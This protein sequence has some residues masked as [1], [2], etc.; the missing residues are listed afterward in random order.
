MKN[1]TIGKRII[2]GFAAILVLSTILAITSFCL[3]KHSSDIAYALATDPLP[4]AVAMDDL[5]GTVADAHI[6]FLRGLIAKTPEDLKALTDGLA[7]NKEH[8]AKAMKDY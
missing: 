8:N 2:A 1:W 5:N 4:G 7:A 6:L 3:L